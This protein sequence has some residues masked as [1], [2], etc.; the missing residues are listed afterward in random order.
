MI[1]FLLEDPFGG[2]VFEFLFSI[3]AFHSVLY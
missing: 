3:F 1:V 2:I